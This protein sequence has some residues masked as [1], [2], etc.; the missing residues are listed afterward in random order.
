M[1]WLILLLIAA[2]TALGVAY[3]SQQGMAQQLIALVALCVVYFCLI[4]WV[5][6]DKVFEDIPMWQ[7]IATTVVLGVIALF[8]QPL[9]EDDHFRY[10]WDG[11]ITATTAKPYALAP[12]AYF[13]ND[14]VPLAMQQVLSAINNPEVPT[15][16]GPVLQAVFALCYWLAPAALWPFKLV[17]LIALL[18]VLQLLRRS[19]VAPRWLLVF[20]L[21]PLVFKESAV[22]AHPDLLI[23][24]ALLAA[25]CAWQRAQ[26]GWAACL[27]S[28]AVAMKFSTI[29]ALPL[30]CID[31]Q[32]RFSQ[33]AGL[34][35][36][37][38]LCIVY[39]PVWLL[40]A[41]GEG[42]ALAALGGQWTF[43]PLLFKLPAAVLG[44]SLAR[45]CVF[46][47]FVVAWIGIF[48]LWI[49]QLRTLASTTASSVAASLP[50]PPIVAVLLALLLL[51]PVVNPWYWLWLLPMAMLRFSWVAWVAATV[52]L[53][54]YSHVLWPVWY[55]SSMVHFAVPA[56]ATLL[57]MLAIAVVVGLAFAGKQW[58][59]P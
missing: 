45:A 13:A 9:L 47:L 24:L 29:A 36:A 18:A 26:H 15:I 2:G 41:G 33:R 56:W 43:N 20:A 7:V 40:I 25:V 17:L 59:M 55:G 39:A 53:L 38:T 49:K 52:S 8:A 58:R 57:Q 16:Y 30:F 4:A 35:M 23:G 32:G 51:S 42:R 34:A 6:L 5:A 44:N 14:A 54:A 21:H 37:L 46:A 19:G 48:L 31:R 50:P 22:T 27:T 28:M 11:Y 12:D 1:R 10:L 3:A